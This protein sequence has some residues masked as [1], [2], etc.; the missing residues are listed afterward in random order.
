MGGEELFSFSGGWII[1]TVM[2]I[3]IA[4]GVLYLGRNFQKKV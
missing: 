1:F 2:S 3:A 4:V